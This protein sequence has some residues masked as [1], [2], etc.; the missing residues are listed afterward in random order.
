M[1]D[2][3]NHFAKLSQMNNETERNLG[4]QPIIELMAKHNLKPHD[5]VVAAPEQ[6]LTHKMVS[7]ACKGRKLTEKTRVKVLRAIN[8]AAKQN[9]AM[10]ELFNY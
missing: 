1:F 6:Q 10:K 2:K 7:R 3:Q 5:L 8:L 4:P 9:Y